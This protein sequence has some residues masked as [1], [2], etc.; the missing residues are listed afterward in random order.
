MHTELPLAFY[1]WTPGLPPAPGHPWHVARLWG[2]GIQPSGVGGGEVTPAPL[3][4]TRM[5]PAATQADNTHPGA[6]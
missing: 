4:G 5:R 2:P 3:R 1:A 6:K